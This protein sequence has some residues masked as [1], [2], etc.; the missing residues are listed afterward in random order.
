MPP[1]C[2]ALSGMQAFAV[3][4]TGTELVLLVVVFFTKAR[5]T[6]AFISLQLQTFNE[7]RILLTIFV[8]ATT[9]L[10]LVYVYVR[11][12][13]WPAPAAAAAAGLASLGG[14]AALASSD[15]STAQHTA[16]TG[17][18]LGGAS[19]YTLLM[20]SLAARHRTLFTVAYV[21]VAVCALL[22]V[23][24]VLTGYDAAAALCEWAGATI[25]AATLM[26]FF[27]D[28]RFERRKQTQVEMQPLLM[29]PTMW[30]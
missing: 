25:N 14:W 11:A 28:N 13:T 9:L 2:P 6:D 1:C 30:V 12:R 24:L 15:M 10:C 4:V 8:I 17:V 7:F 19:V 3:L 18:Y 22:F 23:V 5:A 20:F 29:T 21:V 26:L 27:V 16:G